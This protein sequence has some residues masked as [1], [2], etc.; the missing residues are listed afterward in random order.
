[1]LGGGPDEGDRGRLDFV[2]LGMGNGWVTL[3]SVI[4]AELGGP[5]GQAAFCE[6]GVNTV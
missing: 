3:M 4:C 5:S 2:L 1:M 6:H